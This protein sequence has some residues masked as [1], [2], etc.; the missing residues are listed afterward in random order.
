MHFSRIYQRLLVLFLTVLT[1]ASLGAQEY[2]QKLFAE[3]R[4]RCIGPF[5]VRCS[6]KSQN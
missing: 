2:D 3:M 4:W 5:R 1:G 6:Y